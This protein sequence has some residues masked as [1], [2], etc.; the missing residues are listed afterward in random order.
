[1]PGTVM[2]IRI[3][4]A[5]HRDG[6]KQDRNLDFDPNIT[7]RMAVEQACSILSIP[8]DWN[9]AMYSRKHGGW[10]HDETRLVNIIFK[11]AKSLELRTK[12]PSY[13]E[14]SPSTAL[15]PSRSSLRDSALLRNPTS[16]IDHYKLFNFFRTTDDQFVSKFQ[17]GSIYLSLI[18]LNSDNKILLSPSGLPPTV[19]ISTV[20]GLANYYNFDSD[21]SD[22]AWMFKT[23]LDWAA[24]GPS[25][26]RNARDERLR[27]LSPDPKPPILS[28]P[29]SRG[30][31]KSRSKRGSISSTPCSNNNSGIIINGV[32]N[33]IIN[34]NSRLS[35]SL[36]SVDAS[37]LSDTPRHPSIYEYVDRK[38]D[39]RGENSLRQEY[40]AAVE[41][42]Q[43]K[44]GCPPIELLFDSVVDLPLVGAKTVMA[45]QYAKNYSAK[46]HIA[47]E[48]IQ[49][50][51]YRWRHIDSVSNSVYTR[52]EEIWSQLTSYYDA[53]RVSRPSPGLYVGLYYTESTMSGLQ[54]LVPKLRRTFI[55]MIKLRDKVNLSPEEWSWI[56]STAT[57][58]LDKLTKVNAF[59]KDDPM[60]LLKTQFIQATTKLSQVTQLKWDLSD[61]YGLDTLRV[62]M[63]DRKFQP[64]QPTSRRMSQDSQ[65]VVSDSVDEQKVVP[66][67]AMTHSQQSIV[68]MDQDPIWNNK[69][70]GQDDSNSLRVIMF[71]KPT[72]HATQ[73]QESYNKQLFELCPFPIFDALHHS[74][75]NT[76]TYHQLRKSM[77][78]LTNNIVDLEIEMEQE[79]QKNKGQADNQDK[80]DN[81]NAF[82]NLSHIVDDLDI[83]GESPVNRRNHAHQH[84]RHRSSFIGDDAIH[85]AVF[86]RRL[87]ASSQGGIFDNNV[88]SS[89][90]VASFTSSLSSS[91]TDPLSV[92]PLSFSA[93]A[94]R[95]RLSIT[96]HDVESELSKAF[97]SGGRRGSHTS[98]VE[99]G[100]GDEE[101]P[102]IPFI[103]VMQDMD[104]AADS[105]MSSDLNNASSLSVNSFSSISSSS[106]S[107]SSDDEDDSTQNS[108]RNRLEYSLRR[109]SLGNRRYDSQSSLPPL[110]SLP[111][112]RRSYS[113]VQAIDLRMC[114]IEPDSSNTNGAYSENS[115]NNDTFRNSAGR[116]RTV[117]CSSY[118][119]SHHN[120]PQ[121]PVYRNRFLSGNNYPHYISHIQQQQQQQQ[122]QQHQHQH[123]TNQPQSNDIHSTTNDNNNNE[124]TNYQYPAELVRLEQQQQELQ[125]QWRMASWTRQL[126]EWDH[127][128]M[129]KSQGDLLGIG[130]GVGMSMGIGLD[131]NMNDLDITSHAISNAAI[132]QQNVGIPSPPN[133]NSFSSLQSA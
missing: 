111:R 83:A 25:S 37:I 81:D 112:H 39:Y 34:Q 129:L 89:S 123:S 86:G 6:R 122:Q 15:E 127:A 47:P 16:P 71:V 104:P 133:S 124:D 8:E 28:P 1:M 130:M 108:Y 64:S 3:K 67:P 109:S 75:Y 60:Y 40:V 61:M 95:S 42:M 26:N 32:N 120:Q 23:T 7:C 91:G 128:R 74:V 20:G 118:I 113:L 90:S 115:S 70:V 57:M 100:N 13:F 33:A 36:A 107:S 50:G 11:G 98:F 30:S 29:T 18:V 62:V 31:F 21:S 121:Q 43:Q 4:I 102:P 53:V 80:R 131:M 93:A 97:T 77:L 117:S 38:Q 87:S 59:S 106:S 45:I 14:S 58:D 68:A 10:I 96:E 63:Q 99:R 85:G 51:S 114:S 103:E 49:L 46:D 17:N 24:A 125:E 84:P 12:S 55:P 78:Q 94:S 2:A 116:S 19:L 48:L 69:A 52:R 5:F 65:S 101:E 44:L 56:Q 41:E 76:G 79:S 126:N 72:R 82:Y 66:E 92:G 88:R 22:F 105:I 110:P 54:I 9:L 73:H 35:A 27:S 119:H 132:L